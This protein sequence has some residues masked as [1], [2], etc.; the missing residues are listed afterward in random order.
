MRVEGHKDEKGSPHPPHP[1]PSRADEEDLSPHTSAGLS[2]S[3]QLSF[4]GGRGSETSPPLPA[5]RTPGRSQVGWLL[6]WGAVRPG[7][8]LQALVHPPAGRNSTLAVKESTPAGK[9]APSVAGIWEGGLEILVLD[10]HCFIV[11]SAALLGSSGLAACLAAEGWPAPCMREHA[12]GLRGREG[13][14]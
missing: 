8:V 2:M 12:I 4:S 3:S 7:Q 10:Y 13:G 6:P 11:S 5:C 14:P 9:A 1:V